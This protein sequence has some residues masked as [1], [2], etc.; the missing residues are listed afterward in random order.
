MEHG[1]NDRDF[2]VYERNYLSRKLLVICYFSKKSRR[3]E[4]PAGIRL[5]KGIQVF[6]NYARN[7]VVANGFTARPYELR[8]YLFEPE[9]PK[10]PYD[11]L[12]R[13]L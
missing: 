5:E 2:Y 1:K 12:R 13:P 7:E 8:V 3:F 9:E 6:G 10:D 11:G 4:A